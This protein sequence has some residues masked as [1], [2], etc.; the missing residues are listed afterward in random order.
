MS[1]VLIAA[2]AASLLV[3]CLNTQTANA[4]SVEVCP[5]GGDPAAC[6]GY[7]TIQE[8][9]N[10]A[11]PN[12]VINLSSGTHLAP[13]VLIENKD[14]TIRGK[15]AKDTV[16]QAAN[17]AC[18]SATPDRVFRITSARVRIEPLP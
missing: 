16:V 14:L 13:G 11:A 18:V 6:T 15:G 2:I 4:Q 8:A 12:S 5:P 9:V 10:A 7:A 3:F 1:R 17:T